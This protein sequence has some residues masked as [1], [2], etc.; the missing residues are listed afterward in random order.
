MN[1]IKKQKN[2]KQKERINQR[3]NHTVGYNIKR[4]RIEQGLK[5]SDIICLLQ[6][7]GLNISSS[8]YSKIEAGYNNPTVDML[9][10]L[11]HIY[12]CNYDNFFRDIE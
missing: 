7:Q 1:M 4:L 2:K 5:N 3:E 11:A 8:T 10:A 9:R 12:H 6:L